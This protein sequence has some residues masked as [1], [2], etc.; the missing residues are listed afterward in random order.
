[1]TRIWGMQENLRKGQGLTK[2]MKNSF[3]SLSNPPESVYI[4]NTL[5]KTK[6]KHFKFSCRS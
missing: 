3:L 5:K 4:S 1:M 6:S 2:E